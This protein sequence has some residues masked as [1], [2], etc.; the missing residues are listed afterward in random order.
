M[1]AALA[2]ARVTTATC[3]ARASSIPARSSA[4]AQ[5]FRPAARRSLRPNPSQR[6]GFAAG[7][8]LPLNPE[9]RARIDGLTGAA[10]GFGSGPLSPD[11]LGPDG[12]VVSLGADT[13]ILGIETSCDDTGAAVV[14]GDGRVLGEAKA[15]QDAIHAP[16]GGVVPNLAQEAHKAAIDDVVAAALR[17]A[18]VAASDLSAVAVT[19]GPGLSMCLR[20]GVV[21]A[22]DVCAAAQ[23][24][25][26]PR[27]P[28]GGA[29]PRRAARG[30]HR[31]RQ[32][33][34][35]RAARLGRSQPTHLNP[36]RRRPR[37]LGQHAGRRVGGGV[38]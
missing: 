15:S 20:V 9:R 12:R 16:W 17:D 28:H 37:H 19:V 29:R 26:R 4:P 8:V 36:R 24:P 32:I 2:S 34:V 18:G 22:Q 23:D 25:D 11:R 30:R 31:A 6:R 3:G 10:T 35:P 33:P 7:G 5:G 21:A 14:T 1:R 27:A 38:R 13:L